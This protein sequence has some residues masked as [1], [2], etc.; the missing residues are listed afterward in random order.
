MVEKSLAAS[1]V[2]VT[3]ASGFLGSH[4]CDRLRAC[5]AEVHAVSRSARRSADGLRWWRSDFDDPV[6]V[7]RIL[8]AVKPDLVYHLGGY[9]TSAWDLDKILP[10]FASLLAST[11]Y[12][13]VRATEMGCCRVILAGAYCEPLSAAGIP[14]TPLTAAKWCSTAYARTFHELY[15]T[16]VVVTRP[17][18]TYGP[19][20][21]PH[22]LIPY[23]VTSLLQERAPLLTS[24]SLEADW[25]YVDDVIDGLIRAA[26]APAAV[27]EEVDLGTGNLVSVREVVEMIVA[28][29][30]TA[31]RPEFGALPDRP[32]EQ[33]RAADVE[34]TW[35]LLGWRA[36]T[37]LATGLERAI[38]WHRS[39]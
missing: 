11:V 9:T 17:F 37:P 13:L 30:Q 20:E 24:G 23:V 25:I 38:A 29:M 6:E 27:G 14:R 4:V 39:R 19:R 21:Q 8:R 35:R 12:V 15:G 7:D 10:T 33:V 36:Q 1:R 31:V 28:M 3:G 18:M 2:L 26:T 16:P 22:K 34:R 32:R 5:G